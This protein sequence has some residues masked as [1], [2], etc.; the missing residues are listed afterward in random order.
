MFD[1]SGR[2]ELRPM[3]GD[4]IGT[5]NRGWS[6]SPASEHGQH[7]QLAPT[8]KS[9]CWWVK[10]MYFDSMGRPT[11]HCCFLPLVIVRMF[12]VEHSTLALMA[13]HEH[14]HGSNGLVAT[15]PVLVLQD[16]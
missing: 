8:N 11:L 12:D 5:R 7:S 3:T 2:R 16:V 4:C 9:A 15:M 13:S 10:T 14:C 6:Q 1:W